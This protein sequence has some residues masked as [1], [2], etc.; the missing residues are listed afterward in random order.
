MERQL[1]QVFRE[2]PQLFL[3]N[4]PPLF[5]R[6]E[7][8]NGKGH[9]WSIVVNEVEKKVVKGHTARWTPERRQEQ[10]ERMKNRFRK[11]NGKKGGGSKHT[12]LVTKVHHYLA[13]H[14]ESALRDIMKATGAKASSSVI[15]SMHTGF[16]TGRFVKPGPARYALGPNA[17]EVE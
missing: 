4:A 15:S 14:G 17:R 16:K 11:K 7:L 10:A 3:G 6:P 5:V 9:E 12:G 13:K 8:K 1:A 2:F